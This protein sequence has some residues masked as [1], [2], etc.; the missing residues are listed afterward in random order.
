MIN[1]Y[2]Y[3]TAS[4]FA[5]EILNLGKKMREEETTFGQSSSNIVKTESST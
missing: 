3:D 2:L 5:F 1:E 4:I